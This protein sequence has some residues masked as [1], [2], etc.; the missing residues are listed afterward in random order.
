MC[1]SDRVLEGR[2][3]AGPVVH[4]LAGHRK[5][6]AVDFRAAT[7]QLPGRHLEGVATGLPRK[8]QGQGRSLS[9]DVL[10]ADPGQGELA[11]LSR[12]DVPQDL[13]AEAGFGLQKLQ[14]R[15]IG[16]RN[17]AVGGGCVQNQGQLQ[18][19]LQGRGLSRIH[20]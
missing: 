8:G 16:H 17:F 14:L 18:A 19:G 20:I 3:R 5:G 6:R 7:L 1:I 4:N 2:R 10:G 11:R 15:R 12:I 9:G 13:I